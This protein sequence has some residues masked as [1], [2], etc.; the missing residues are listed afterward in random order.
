MKWTRGTVALTVS[1]R[2]NHGAGEVEKHYS[3]SMEIQLDPQE[4]KEALDDE[5]IRELDLKRQE[6]ER[7]IDGWLGD[8]G[9]RE[10]AE[11]VEERLKETEQTQ[12]D[13]PDLQQLSPEGPR[14]EERREEPDADSGQPD[15]ASNEVI[16]PTGPVTPKQASHLKGL[17]HRTGMTD[18]VMAFIRQQYGQDRIEKLG[19]GQASAVITLLKEDP[20]RL[21]EGG[22]G[23]AKR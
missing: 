7:I 2:S 20:Q 23:Q 15:E 13:K 16:L 17:A 1:R 18:Q 12:E 5:T 4:Q 11:Y 19:K 14:Q 6:L 9:P 21:Q 22:G 3:L 10:M 8:Y